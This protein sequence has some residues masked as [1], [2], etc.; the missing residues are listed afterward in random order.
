MTMNCKSDLFFFFDKVNI[1]TDTLN[2]S[3][4]VESMKLLLI[5]ISITTD[6]NMKPGTIAAFGNRTIHTY[7]SEGAGELT[8]Y[9][10]S[11]YLII[12]IFFSFA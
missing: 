7:H 3:G 9:P 11:G 12:Q 10:I 2:E 4:F 5:L 8:M 6:G 1:H